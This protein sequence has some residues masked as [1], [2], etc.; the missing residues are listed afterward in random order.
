MRIGDEESF[1]EEVAF[2]LDGSFFNVEAEDFEDAGDDL[3]K[4][5]AVSGSDHEERAGRVGFGL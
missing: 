1:D 2:E 3:E 5:D 4:A